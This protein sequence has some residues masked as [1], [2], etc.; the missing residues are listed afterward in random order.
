[1]NLK[2]IKKKS[3]TNRQMMNVVNIWL[4]FQKVENITV[5]KIVTKNLRKLIKE[6]QS[7]EK[8]PRSSTT[9]KQE[10]KIL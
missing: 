8:F 4:K 7:N 10:K 3:S 1:M 2:T 9:V 6:K 5:E